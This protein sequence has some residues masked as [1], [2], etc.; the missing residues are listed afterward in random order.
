VTQAGDHRWNVVELTSNH[1]DSFFL[2]LAH[3]VSSDV[4]SFCIGLGSTITVV[5]YRFGFILV[6]GS[7][8]G[9]LQISLHSDIGND[10]Q[11]CQ[12]EVNKI[13]EKASLS[14]LNLNGEM[15]SQG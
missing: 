14:R 12:M 1:F 8:E 10:S 4:A 15:V 9:L 5:L 7:L 3:Q 13:S 6:R 2:V 11:V